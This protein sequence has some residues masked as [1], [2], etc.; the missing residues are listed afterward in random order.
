M[1]NFTK[2][3]ITKNPNV[4]QILFMGLSISLKLYLFNDATYVS[5]DLLVLIH[6]LVEIFRIDV[7]QH[8]SCHIWKMN[9]ISIL[10]MAS[11]ILEIKNHAEINDDRVI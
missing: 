6:K 4:F 8:A 3:E 5:F 10:G 9:N 7:R 11:M 2:F 1:Q